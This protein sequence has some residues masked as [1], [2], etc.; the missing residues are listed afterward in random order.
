MLCFFLFFFC[1][2]FIYFEPCYI[3]PPHSLSRFKQV[4]NKDPPKIATKV[5]LPTPYPFSPPP[6]S[7]ASLGVSCQSH[8]LTCSLSLSVFHAVAY[9]FL[10]S[11]GSFSPRFTIKG[12]NSHL[13]E[14]ALSSQKTAS[15]LFVSQFKSWLSEINLMFFK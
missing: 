12:C 6:H 1:L 14:T 7:A 11:P 8:S 10:L 9:P 13:L 2:W 3:S 15:S 5:T 4:K